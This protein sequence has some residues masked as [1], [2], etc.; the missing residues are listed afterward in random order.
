[1]LT[2]TLLIQIMQEVTAPTISIGSST[3]TAHNPNNERQNPY[4][5]SHSRSRSRSLSLSLTLSVS[6][7]LSRIVYSCLIEAAYR[8]LTVKHKGFSYTQNANKKAKKIKSFLMQMRNGHMLS[9]LVHTN[10]RSNQGLATR[11]IVYGPY[12]TQIVILFAVCKQI[13]RPHRNDTEPK[14][15]T[16]RRCAAVRVATT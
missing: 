5:H 16:F 15:K 13:V 6:L 4:S 14:L 3:S 11:D 10:V 9:S 1:M 7:N 12:V 2:L 8:V